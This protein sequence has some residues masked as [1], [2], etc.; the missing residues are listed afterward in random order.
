MS[1]PKEEFQTDEMLIASLASLTP[2][3]EAINRQN[4]M[5]EEKVPKDLAAFILT[6]TLWTCGGISREY[7]K[8][9][10]GAVR[11]GEWLKKSVGEYIKYVSEIYWSNNQYEY[12]EHYFKQE[13]SVKPFFPNKI[14]TIDAIVHLDEAYKDAPSAIHLFYY[15]PFTKRKIAISNKLL[16]YVIATMEHLDVKAENYTIHVAQPNINYYND[17]TYSFEEVCEL[18]G[19]IACKVELE[20]ITKEILD[21]EEYYARTRKIKC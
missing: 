8:T 5:N 9:L 13:M 4:R 6:N 16:L 19:Y 11:Y 2:E 17:Y 3:I 20:L 1:E 15:K 21:K 12:Q 7:K 14:I 10:K 18:K